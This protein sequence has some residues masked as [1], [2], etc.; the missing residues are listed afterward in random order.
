VA[1]TAMVWDGENAPTIATAVLLADGSMLET[2]AQSGGPAPGGDGRLVSIGDVTTVNSAGQVLLHATVAGTHGGRSDGSG[3]YRIDGDTT[4]AIARVGQQAPGGGSFATLDT[5]NSTVSNM[6]SSVMNEEGQ[7]A[8][9]ASVGG[10]RGLFLYDDALGLLQIARVGDRF[11]GS[12][13][14]ALSSTGWDEPT[15][16]EVSF[17]ERGQLAYNFFLADGRSGVAVWSVPEPTAAAA[18]L[19]LGSAWLLRR[20]RRDVDAD[21]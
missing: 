9:S 1:F 7:V 4:T 8:F 6:Y 10:N 20:R 17:N 14:R 16:S 18:S 13:I 15:P 5:T 2:L 11:L 21:C 12:T 3:L 19:G